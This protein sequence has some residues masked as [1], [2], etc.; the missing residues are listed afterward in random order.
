MNQGITTSLLQQTGFIH[1]TTESTKPLLSTPFLPQLRQ[2]SRH[3]HRRQNCCQTSELTGLLLPL[4]FCL[5][6]HVWPARTSRQGNAPHL[7]AY[8]TPPPEHIL[9]H[10]NQVQRSVVWPVLV[11]LLDWHD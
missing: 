6:I 11:R 8:S 2:H 1:S 5:H 7:A 10:T 9:H 4:F 3:D